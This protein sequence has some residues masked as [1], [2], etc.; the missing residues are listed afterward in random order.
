[1]TSSFVRLMLEHGA[2]V[3][4]TK[5]SFFRTMTPLHVAA[6]IGDAEKCKLL[7]EFKADVNAHTPDGATPLDFAAVWDHQVVCELL[8]AHGAQLVLQTASL[9]AAWMTPYES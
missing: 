6:N 3:N 8:L 1:M 7:L 4:D 5:G 2:D 9:L